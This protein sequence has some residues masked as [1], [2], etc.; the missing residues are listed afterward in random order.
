V[1][2]G[3]NNEKLAVL[4]YIAYAC[5]GAVFYNGMVRKRPFE[6]KKDIAGGTAK[7]SGDGTYFFEKPAKPSLSFQ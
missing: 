1:E 4:F 3:D 2:R 7:A 5:V 6:A